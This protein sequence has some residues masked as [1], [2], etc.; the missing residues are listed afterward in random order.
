MWAITKHIVID[1]R[2]MHI[3]I[4]LQILHCLHLNFA[5]SAHNIIIFRNH[6]TRIPNPYRAIIGIFQ[7]ISVNGSS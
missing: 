4:I 7:P 2:H 3:V 5:V 6:N 1:S